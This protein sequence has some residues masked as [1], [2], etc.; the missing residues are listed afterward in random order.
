MS[1][2]WRLKPLDEKILALVATATN[3]CYSSEI[4][5]ELWK[6]P[7]NADITI[8]DVRGR[9]IWLKA[10]QFLVNREGYERHTKVWRLG[11]NAYRRLQQETDEG[12]SLRLYKATQ[13]SYTNCR[14]CEL[15]L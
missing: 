6:D 1:H 7:A 10:R 12:N 8:D 5:E 11:P 13:I 4:I 14:C 9:M 2:A 3:G 15:G